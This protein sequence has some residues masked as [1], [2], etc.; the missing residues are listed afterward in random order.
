VTPTRPTRS[1]LLRTSLALGIVG[2]GPACGDDGGTGFTATN[3]V[4]P[5]GASN[6]GTTTTPT[7]GDDAGD[8]TT[9]T[10]PTGPATTNPPCAELTLCPETTTD[11]TTTTT[12]PTTIDPPDTTTTQDPPTDDPCSGAAD[13]AHCGGDLGGLADHGSLYT[14][15]GGATQSATPCPAGCEGDACKIPQADPCASAQ[16]GNGDYCGGTLMNGDAGSLYTCQDGGTA[17][18]QPCPTG[19]KVN[20]PGFA[21]VCNPEGDPCQNAQ[22]GDGAYCGAGLGGDPNVLYDCVGMAT[23]SSETCANGCK[24]NDPGTPDECLPPPNGGECCL[25]A[26][27]G[28]ITQNYSACGQGGSH[29]GIDYG[30][31]VGTPIYAGMSGTV[32]GSALGFPNCYNNGCSPSCWNA[33]NYLKIKA[34]CGDPNNAANDLFIYYLHIDSIAPGVGDGTH[35]DQGQLAALSGNS[36]CSSG[37]HIHIETASVPKGQNATLNTCSSNDPDSVYCP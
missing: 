13:G 6:S 19:C 4:T 24:V 1:H 22:A 8:T 33:F 25:D 14:C 26:P 23:G 12:T 27:P 21:D 31:A 7:T 2:L 3:P 18:K 15:S 35:L 17:N 29:Y 34:D 30:T 10:E 16:S 20:P 28:T 9:T 11:P 36:G 37:P 5:T 32:V